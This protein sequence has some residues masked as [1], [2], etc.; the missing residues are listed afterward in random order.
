MWVGV[1]ELELSGLGGLVVNYIFHNM[2]LLYMTWI[3]FELEQPLKCL[4]DKGVV[5]TI[6]GYHKKGGVN[7]LKFR[8]NIIGKVYVLKVGDIKGFEVITVDRK[9][10]S[11]ENYVEYSGFSKVEEWIGYAKKLNK[12]NKL[13]LYYVRLIQLYYDPFREGGG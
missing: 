3:N 6:R 9:K 4:I 13:S 10:L 2:K 12:H 1:T 5:Y 7:L 8:G 11:L